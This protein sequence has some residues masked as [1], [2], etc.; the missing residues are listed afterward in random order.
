M[1]ALD[2]RTHHLNHGS[3]GAVPLEVLER[4]TEWRERWEANPTAFISNDLQPALDEARQSVSEFL[5]ADSDGLVFVRNASSG[6]ASVIRSIE[7]ALEAGDE[8]LTTAQDYNA[9]RQMLEYSAE[10]HEA[11]VVVAEVPFPVESPNQ[12]TEA[13]LSKAGPRT[14][15]AVIDHIT[16]PTALIYPVEEMVAAL[17][18]HVPVL[19]DG[20][21]GPGQ[22]ALDVDEIGAS[23]YTGNLHKWTC[24]PK[25]S[26]FLHAR[27]DRRPETV[28]T[29]IS[30]GRNAPMPEIGDRYRLLFDWLGTDDFSQWLVVPDALSAVGALEPGGWA[31]LRKRNHELILAARRLLASSVGSELPAP[32]EMIGTMAAIRLPDRGGEHPGGELSPL[33]DELIDAGF[34]TL[35]MNWPSWPS[36]LLRV[37]A[38]HYNRLEEY[39]ALANALATLL[40]AE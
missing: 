24:A 30:H 16:S 2:P 39:E 29:V 33:M 28:P 3:F 34:E 6:V 26:A 21:H 17:E 9:V 25:G 36:Q 11:K 7:P 37:S 1:W 20:A 10:R 18:P 32:D 13:V 4:Q 38:H 5:G 31:A 27:A 22:I 35:V 15:L 23:W 8:L 12:V 40:D 19:V 14:K